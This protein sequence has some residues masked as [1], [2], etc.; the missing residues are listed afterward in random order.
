MAT[1]TTFQTMYQYAQRRLH[2]KSDSNAVTI[3]KEATNRAI[4][5][6]AE[7][8]DPHYIKQGYI[9]LIEPYTTGTV[10]VAEG[11]TTVSG[12]GVTWTSAME[13]RYMKIDDEQVHFLLTSMETNNKFTFDGSAKWLNDAETAATYS[14]YQDRYSWPSDFRRVAKVMETRLLRQVEWL[15]T[16]SEWF[17]KKQINHSLTGRPRW[18]CMGPDK[19]FIWPYDTDITVLP[20]LYYYWP[21]ELSA[22]ATA[23]DYPDSRMDL[24]RRAI[25]WEIAIERNDPDLIMRAEA[26]FLEKENE[27]K[28][29]A[30]RPNDIFEIGGAVPTSVLRYYT[31]G[32]D[33]S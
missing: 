22:D 16:P 15:N 14:I 27:L 5:R 2:N 3:C 12:T 4:R 23:V 31:I 9:N 6:I 30:T 32:A 25:D 18:G 1:T 26:R 7:R 17:E 33:S 8:D 29:A 24:V 21:T 19:L 13:G 20:F 28:A 11:G 10:V